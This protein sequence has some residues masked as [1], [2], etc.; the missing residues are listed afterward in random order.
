MAKTVN[1]DA[2]ITRE[3]FAAEDLCMTSNIQ[4]AVSIN[5]LQGNY[6]TS[7]IRKPDF[8]R[9]THD[10]TIDNV[11][12]FI[13]SVVKGQ[14]IPS[15]I[16]WKNSGGFIFVIDGAHRLSALL[17]WMKD[18]YGDG[19]I[20]RS[21]FQ[22]YI[23]E[24]QKRVAESL[25]KRINKEVGQYADYEKALVMTDGY[26]EEFVK[27]ARRLRSFAFS[28][29]WITGDVT[30]AEESFYNINQRAVSINDTELKLI[31]SRKC[32]ICIAA[33]AIMYSGSGNKYWKEFSNERQCEIVALSKKINELLFEPRYDKP[34]KTLDLP[35]CGKNQSNL[36]FIF[37]LMNF[38]ATGKSQVDADGTLTVRCLAELK[39]LLETISSKEPDSLGLHP[40]VYFYSKKGNFRVS[41][42]Y[43]VLGFVKYIKEKKQMN[44]FTSVRESFESFIYKYDY[45]VDQIN[46]SL[47]STKKSVPVL[48]Q[49]YIDVLKYLIE[50]KNFDEAIQEISKD[51]SYPKF[52]LEQDEEFI[53]TSSFNSNR[54]SEVFIKQAFPGAM[55]CPICGGLLHV[56][57]ISIDH[58]IRKQ[59]G[60]QSHS[61]NGQAAHFYCNTTYK[62]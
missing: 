56:N 17:A 35:M 16:L 8:Q 11:I 60:G 38:S 20:S 49:F 25:R 58:I 43:A 30:T 42:F 2:M 32:D 15:L 54:K 28:I 41:A 45:V 14:F 57:S 34:I 62:N 33:R 9:E 39:E 55:K 18:D 50:G 23:S 40:I 12:K 47:R 59:D 21:F 3:D 10:W 5:D 19:P 22:G 36:T 46:R 27:T 48:T 61:T 7:V 29:Q 44:N 13:D 51:S 53:E 31:Q 37:D 1:L 6:L 26:T 52:L 24:E 4:T